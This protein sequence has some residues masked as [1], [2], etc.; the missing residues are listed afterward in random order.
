M[1][2]NIEFLMSLN[3]QTSFIRII[4]DLSYLN[5]AR[6]RVFTCLDLISLQLSYAM[7]FVDNFTLRA[8]NH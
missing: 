7:A 2:V 4:R 8:S 3:T 5:I 6:K 1:C